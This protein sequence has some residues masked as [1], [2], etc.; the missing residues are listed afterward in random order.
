MK[1]IYTYLMM[2]TVS[3]LII[4]CNEEWSGEQYEHYIS[5]KAPINSD[6]VSR[7]NVRYKANEATTYQV[8]LIVSGTTLNDKNYTVRIGLDPDTLVVLNK[9]RYSTRI[10]LYYQVLPATFYSLPETVEIKAG[11]NTALL[12]IDFKLNNIDLS[13][14]WVLPLTVEESSDGSY[15]LIIVSIIAKHYSVLCL[16]M[17]IRAIIVQ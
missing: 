6:G 12:P 5:F 13:E 10:D 4:S 11:E 15:T 7:I 14:K 8:P 16:L 1:K 17:I 2:L 9:E 3:A